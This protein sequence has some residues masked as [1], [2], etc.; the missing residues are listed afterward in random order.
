MAGKK[1][2][3]GGA[4]WLKPYQRD[5][6]FT[7]A[8][9]SL[10][11][12]STKAGKTIACLA[13]LLEQAILTGQPGRSFWW[14]APTYS[15]GEIAFRRMKHAIP[16]G[17]VHPNESKL[18]LTLS[19][20][21]LIEFR[22]AER[23]DALYGDDVYAAVLDEASRM[24]E[25]AWHAVRSTLTATRGPVRIIG[26]VRGRK[27]WFYK[28]ARIAEAGDPDMTFAR[29][30]A[31]EAAQAGVI[32]NEEVQAARRDF[33][34]LGRMEV[35]KELYLAEAADDGGNPFGLQAIENCL[36]RD[37]STEPARAAGIDLAGRGAKNATE[38]GDRGNLDYTA[39]TMLDRNGTA[40]HI[41]RFRS[42]NAEA[43]QRIEKVVGR[44]P[45]LGDSTG[46]GDPII[47]MLQRGGRM[48]IEGYVFSV[49]T[50]QD[51][52]EH[53][54]V[55][56]QNEEIHFPDG[57]LRDELDGFEFEYTNSGLRYTQIT[58][59][60]DDLSMSLAL[61]AWKLPKRRSTGAPMGIAG[62][63]RWNNDPATEA[64]R[65][66]AETTKP[67]ESPPAEAIEG[68]DKPSTGAPQIITGSGSG[69]WR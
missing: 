53:L 16:K 62:V 4:P 24:R 19:N 60:H 26:N 55:R 38:T 49:R 15:Q 30:T 63:S 14:V 39:I 1:I 5:A 12:S 37:L 65:K 67:T 44:T 31:W 6:L 33:E 17:M 35:F 43:M 22:S 45:A 54:A 7:D 58:G 36:V 57:D 23:P 20:G 40:T 59:M 61:A 56:I 11:E 34:R 32:D 8:R 2:E 27:N 42:P 51:L 10:V 18:R 47:E 13:W 21:A 66:Y 48:N 28:L 41:E 3:Y 69:K 46:A 25:E 68:A 9:V 50:R 29:I 64:W 52:L